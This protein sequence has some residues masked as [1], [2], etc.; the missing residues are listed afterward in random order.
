MQYK[1]GNL[2]HVPWPRSRQVVYNLSLGMSVFQTYIQRLSPQLLHALC[3]LRQNPD[4]SSCPLK[5][6][7]LPL[8]MF[9]LQQPISHQLQ[10]GKRVFLCPGFCLVLKVQLSI[11][12]DP[13]IEKS[14]NKSCCKWLTKEQHKELMV[15]FCLPLAGIILHVRAL[16]TDG[17][18]VLPK[19]HQVRPLQP[20]KSR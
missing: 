12:V 19:Q 5:F 14:N 17:Y 3:T 18:S 15:T 16:S 9:S 8:L 11:Q 4:S 10:L 1:A 20:K 7:L 13:H 6:P 2:F